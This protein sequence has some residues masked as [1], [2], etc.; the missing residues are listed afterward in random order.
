MERACGDFQRNVK[1]KSAPGRNLDKR[2]LRIA[3]MNQLESRFDL[4]EELSQVG[5]RPKGS[6]LRNEAVREGCE[7]C[8]P[9]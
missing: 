4:A 3:Y 6:I 5:M 7:C 8:K 1:S 2:V 9:P